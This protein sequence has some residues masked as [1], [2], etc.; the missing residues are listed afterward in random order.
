MIK[1]GDIDVR[2]KSQR[3]FEDNDL[4]KIKF[5]AKAEFFE[6]PFTERRKNL[7]V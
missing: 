2:M 7:Q 1:E 4:M 5:S 3:Y 6:G